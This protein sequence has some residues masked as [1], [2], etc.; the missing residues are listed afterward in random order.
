M[1]LRTIFFCGHRSPYG[2]AHLAPILESK[3][4]VIAV[5]IATDDRWQHF[6]DALGSKVYS[7]LVSQQNLGSVIKANIKQKLPP[8]LLKILKKPLA[9]ITIVQELAGQ[10]QIPVW[11]IFDANE[12]KFLEQVEA[13]NPDLILSAGYPQIFAKDL[14]SIPKKGSI[15]FHPSLLPKFRGAHPHFWAIAKGE[16]V[17]GM[18]AHFMTENL[19]DGDIVAQLEIPIE[20]CTYAEFYQQLIQQTPDL[21]NLVIDFLENK[22][23]IAIP[24][25][26]SAGCLFRND[27][28][29]HHRIFWQIQTTEEIHNLCRTGKAFCFFRN[30]KIDCLKTYPK[31]TNR[32]L[33]NFIAVP[34]STIIDID[35]DSIVIKTIDTCLHIQEIKAKGK[36]FSAH[37]WI[38]AYQVQIGEQLN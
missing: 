34:A 36:L 11:Q 12:Q 35:H 33:T 8:I 7:Q 22:N 30:I 29:I 21:V 25:N 32:N 6:G 31:P 2:L 10:N 9:D 19:D 17:S 14:I 15:N 5:V 37:Q 16:K 24:Q 26:L 27:R 13:A 4:E 3:L 18:T 1:K 20:Q 23:S 38:K 28:P